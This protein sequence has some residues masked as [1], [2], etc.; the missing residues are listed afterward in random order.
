MSLSTKDSPLVSQASKENQSIRLALPDT[1]TFDDVLLVPNYAD[2]LPHEVILKSP[3][4][5]NITLNIPL[6]SSAMDTV[7]EARL[8]IAI[9][10]EGGLGVI[11]KNLALDVQAKEV[12]KVKKHESGVVKDPVTASPDMSVAELLALTRK[13][14]FSGVPVV[15]KGQVIG[16]VTSRDMRFETS[17]SQPIKNIMTPQDKLITVKEGTKREDVIHLLHKHRIE[18]ILVIDDQFSLKG[19]VT[20][21]DIQKAIDKPNAC[22]DSS[23]QLR[24][25]A[26][27]STSKDAKARIEALDDAGVDVIVVD[28]AHGHSKG[29]I[30]QV[31][32][33]KNHYP[34][35]DVIA[36]NIATVD[37][38]KALANAGA[39]A[40]KVGI[41]PGSIC[42]TRIVTG[43][44]MPQLS[45]ISEVASV[46]KPLGI[47][48][49]GDGGIRF[50][51][52]IT[53]ALAAGASSV[54]IGSL[55][56]GTDESPGK[57]ELLEGRSYKTYQGMGSLESMSKGSKDRY[58]QENVGDEKL[59][60][61][62][63]VGRV[64]YKGAFIN[65]LHQ[66]LGGLRAG[67]GYIG[68]KT[69][70]EMHQ[71]A[72]FVRVSASG[73]NENHV[74]DITMM[75]EPPNYSKR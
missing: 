2:F 15:E 58:F 60:P 29:V 18:K 74:H 51:G 66:L 56:A 16:L 7:T 26:A 62:G 37:A 17:L 36:G 40:V 45:A 25:G 6:I 68:C 59:I 38:A 67:M 20:V 4:T 30:E 27:V 46:L 3:L 50:S 11:H 73:V 5:R 43:I 39:D 47:P 55:F 9:A 57:V 52:D 69:I 71:K 34:H 12:Q 48:L 13:H 24:V 21:K 65:V 54:M 64:P 61:E 31:A 44:G 70:V 35:I 10:Q 22:K 23:G 41:G 75:K 32:W 14:H 33:I 1:L 28:T 42:I 49:I 63:V 8:A 53:K 19:L 72:H